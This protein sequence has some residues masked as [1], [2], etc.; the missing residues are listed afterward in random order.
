MARCNETERNKTNFCISGDVIELGLT[1]RVT[2][3]TDTI[4]NVYDESDFSVYKSVFEYEATFQ[5]TIKQVK[6]A[7][8]TGIE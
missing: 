1:G 8:C 6:V 4:T 5:A 2:E 7:V 3:A